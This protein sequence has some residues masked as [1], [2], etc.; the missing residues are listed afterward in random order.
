M[1]HVEKYGERIR[2]L[3]TTRHMR[4]ACWTTKAKNTHS[5]YVTLIDFPW[6]QWLRERAPRYAIRTLCLVNE[7]PKPIQYKNVKSL[8]RSISF[9]SLCL[10]D[11]KKP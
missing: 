8:R 1:R 7:W 3:M 10:I 9:S 4:R 11:S 2:P 5:E 6:Q